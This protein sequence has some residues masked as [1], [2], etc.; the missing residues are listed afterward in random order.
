MSKTPS[1]C[2]DHASPFLSYVT[3]EGRDEPITLTIIETEGGSRHRYPI[4]D[5][6]WLLILSEVAAK[7]ASRP[8]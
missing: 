4:T 3:S 6:R 7:L 8:K 1:D 5:S 2:I